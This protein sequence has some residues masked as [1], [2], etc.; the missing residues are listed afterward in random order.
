[1]DGPLHL[2]NETRTELKIIKK[3][4]I[5]G[6]HQTETDYNVRAQRQ[7]FT[8]TEKIFQIIAPIE[9]FSLA[10]KQCHN[11]QKKIICNLGITQRKTK[12]DIGAMRD[13]LIN[14]KITIE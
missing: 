2:F 1:M 3:S 13:Y 6:N 11:I 14:I 9:Q 7:K 5:F 10:A 12:R 8:Q 4:K